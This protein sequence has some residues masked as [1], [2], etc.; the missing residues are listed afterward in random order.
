MASSLAEALAWLDAHADPSVRDQMGSRYGIHTE[1]ALGVPMRDLQALAKDLGRSHELAAE[2][3]ATGGYEARTVAALVDEPALV[4]VDQ[5]DRWAADFDN[6]A[7]CDTVCFHLFDRAAPAWGRVPV[8][9]A[10]DREFVRRGSFALVWALALHD[11]T[12]ADGSFAAVLDLLEAGAAD[13]RPLVGKAVIMAMRAI[14]KKRPA[15]LPAV[16]EAAERLA[17]AD[18]AAPRQVGRAVLRG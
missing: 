2:L 17:A 5:M 1:H 12:A 18:G 4:S 7:I 11:R 13:E 3:W 8:W 10:D 16:R 6:W 9:A 15:L 14:G